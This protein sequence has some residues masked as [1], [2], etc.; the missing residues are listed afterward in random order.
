MEQGRRRTRDRARALF[1]RQE[2]KPAVGQRRVDLRVKGSPSQSVH[3]SVSGWGL[4]SCRPMSSASY[5]LEWTGY[6]TS[7]PLFYFLFCK[8]IRQLYRSS[9][10]LFVGQYLKTVAMH[11][12]VFWGGDP[13]LANSAR[14]ELQGGWLWKAPECHTLGDIGGAK[15]GKIDRV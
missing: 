2:S 10:P 11:L 15:A 8:A 3:Q 5:R 13:S 1:T 14:G 9:D 7:L 4:A 12:M 6:W